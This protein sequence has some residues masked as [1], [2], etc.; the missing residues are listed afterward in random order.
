M[1]E[2]TLDS[3][4][5]AELVRVERIG[6][7]EFLQAWHG[8]VQTTI[9]TPNP[10]GDHPLRQTETWTLSDEKGES[11]TREAVEEHMTEHF[12]RIREERL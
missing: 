7:T 12:E 4:D 3:L 10:L 9:Y 8:G 6:A 11:P 2:T 5:G 1:P